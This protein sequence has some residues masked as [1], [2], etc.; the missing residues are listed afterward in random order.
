MYFGHFGGLAPYPKRAGGKPP[1]EA[2]LLEANKRA[3]PDGY[4]RD[5][6]SLV[7]A[8]HI[9]EARADA[10][11]AKAVETIRRDS[12]PQTAHLSLRDWAARLG[13]AILPDWTEHDLARAVVEKFQ[14]DAKNDILTLRSKCAA[15]L[16]DSFVALKRAGDKQAK[17]ISCAATTYDGASV[18]PA[19]P[20]EQK[21]SGSNTS[22]D[23]AARL[24]QCIA[25]TEQEVSYEIATPGSMSAMLSLAVTDSSV[26]CEDSHVVAASAAGTL[27]DSVTV[28]EGCTWLLAFVVIRSGVIDITDVTYNGNPMTL[29]DSV[30]ANDGTQLLHIAAYKRAV[31][32]PDSGDVQVVT[33]SLTG[34]EKTVKLFWCL[35]EGLGTITSESVA[36]DDGS[37]RTLTTVHTTDTDAEATLEA[38]QPTYWEGNPAPDALQP[39]LLGGWTSVRARYRLLARRGKTFVSDDAVRQQIDGPVHEYL[40]R[41]LKSS[42]CYD[43]SIGDLEGFI[44]G[45]SRLG[46]VA[47]L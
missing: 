43:Y 31:T 22:G 30:T 45:V 41:V 25:A 7:V 17:V 29:V 4:S 24:A 23:T 37:E 20:L 39:Y 36:D 33:G 35:S 5:D 13:V 38:P 16:G 3:Y 19:Y 10:S 46:Y 27:A 34:S 44:L 28:V 21:G 18:T 2:L 32:Y 9:A 40:D 6:N 11:V 42:E 12:L 47:M 1:I 8:E 15:L 14:A 26:W